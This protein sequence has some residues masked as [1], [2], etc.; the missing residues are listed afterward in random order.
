MGK[1]PEEVRAFIVA[2]SERFK[3]PRDKLVALSARLPV[4]I[5]S[6][7]LENAKRFGAQIRR[8]GGEVSLRRFVK[9]APRPAE[10]AP[11]GDQPGDSWVV[12]GHSES[13]DDLRSMSSG[14]A[15][16]TPAAE[17]PQDERPVDAYAGVFEGSAPVPERPSRRKI[18]GKYEP[19]HQYTSDE[20]FGLSDERFQK[21]KELYAGRKGKRPFTGSP[22]FKAILLV[23]IAAVAAII[24]VR[25]EEIG[26][27]IFGLK[28]AVLADAYEHRLPASVSVPADLT[29]S[30]IGTLE[31]TTSKGDVAVVNVTLFIE[32]KNVHDVVVEVTSAAADIGNYRLKIEYAPGYIMYSKTVNDKV[33]YTVENSFPS[34]NNAI[35]RIDD[36]GR[37]YIVVEALD[38]GI[39]PST[40]PDSEKD[41]LGNMIFLRME[42]AFA[43]DDRFFG[44]LLT[45]GSPLVGWEAVKR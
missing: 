5:G 12:H 36:R 34:S 37:F 17:Q 25:W 11:A 35:S 21:V 9:E 30:Y 43:G 4:K 8:M 41:H 39:N 7:D 32:G 13:Q 18:G 6:Y 23:L 24:Y 42:G 31:Y 40:I 27:L 28:K 38:A 44:G 29:G 15:S 10:A 2:F 1:T 45:S 26:T 3:V 33:I 22:A 14:A 20:G 19:K 16:R